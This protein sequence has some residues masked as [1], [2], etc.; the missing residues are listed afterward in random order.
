MIRVNNLNRFTSE[1]CMEVLGLR[2]TKAICRKEIDSKSYLWYNVTT[3]CVEVVDKITNATLQINGRINELLSPL[4]VQYLKEHKTTSSAYAR[5]MDTL[6]TVWIHKK[7]RF[8]GYYIIPKD[9]IQIIEEK[10]LLFHQVPGSFCGTA[11]QQPHPKR[12]LYS[13]QD[14]TIF[15]YPYQRLPFYSIHGGHGCII[16]IRTDSVFGDIMLV[17]DHPWQFSKWFE[18]RASHRTGGIL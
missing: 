2:F 3:G 1:L 18:F 17:C 13:D 12:Q 6:N 8:A 4:S 10:S 7:K 16:F 15:L 9:I 11:I 14:T 5:I